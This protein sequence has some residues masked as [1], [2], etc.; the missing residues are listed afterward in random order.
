[1]VPRDTGTGGVLEMMVLP[2]LAKGNYECERQVQ[3]GERLGGGKHVVDA[4]AK[5]KSGKAFLISLKWQQVQGTAEQKVPFEVICLAEAVESS[6]GKYEKAYLVL[7]G[8]GWKLRKFYIRG[9]LD[10][11]FTHAHLVAIVSLENFVAK[12]NKGEL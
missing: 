6:H 4:V 10:P 12:A 5:D 2:S 8:E 11:H 9:G 7:G 1:M 3:V